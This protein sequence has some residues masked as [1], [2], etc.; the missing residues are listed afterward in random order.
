VFK[1]NKENRLSE[2]DLRRVE[3]YLSGPVQRVERK[4]FRPWLLLFWL[5][6][7]VMLLGGVSLL[8]G[9]IEGYV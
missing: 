2:D 1:D 9:Q 8:L 5:W 3:E 4:P 6:V 7:V